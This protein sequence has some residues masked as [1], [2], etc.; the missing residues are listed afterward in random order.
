MGPH[1]SIVRRHA[2]FV[3]LFDAAVMTLP[4]K[5]KISQRERVRTFEL[6][7]DLDHVWEWHA[8]SKVETNEFDDQPFDGQQ[9]LSVLLKNL[10]RTR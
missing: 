4:S 2:S 10:P 7:A 6:S 5:N 1:L 8:G 9:S 3:N